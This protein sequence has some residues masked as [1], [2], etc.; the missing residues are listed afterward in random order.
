VKKEEKRKELRRF[1]RNSF[2]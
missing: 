1:F 2:C